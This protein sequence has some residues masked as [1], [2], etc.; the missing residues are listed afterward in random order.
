MYLKHFPVL[1]Q[2]L[3]HNICGKG[4]WKRFISQVNLDKMKEEG[5]L[6]FKAY[7]LFHQ[8]VIPSLWTLCNVGI[9]NTEECF[10]SQKF[11]LGRNTV[12]E[13]EQKHQK[14]SKYAENTTIQY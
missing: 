5:H 7:F 9:F 11:G 6:L 8:K 2:M 10:K 4:I 1:I 3:I 13:R 12:E 14:I